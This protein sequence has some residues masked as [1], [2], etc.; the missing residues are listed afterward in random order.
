MQN[1]RTFLNSL[2]EHPGVYEMQNEK[3]ETIY[4]GKARNLKKRLSSYFSK[5][6]KDI[7]TEKLLTHVKDIK[8]IV[9]RT[10]NEA[11]LLEC[12]LIKKVRPH[13]NVLFRDD[14]SYPYIVIQDSHPFPAIQFY[15]GRPKKDGWYFGPYPNSTAVRETLNF[16]Q[17]LF[18]LRTCNDHFYASRTRPCLEYQLGRC[19]GSCAGLISREDYQHDI[20]HAVLFLQGKNTQIIEELTQ[21]MESAVK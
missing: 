13:Y 14:K 9:T 15:R 17:K 21:Q 5:K 7:K 6:T 11:L 1:V 16:I 10:E 19:S 18:R 4:I 2:S 20:R 12:N 8:V 3:D